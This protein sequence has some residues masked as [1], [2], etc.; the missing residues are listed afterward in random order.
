MDVCVV[1]HEHQL[2]GLRVERTDFPIIPP[3]QDALPIAHEPHAITLQI[4]HLNSQQLLPILRIPHPN[5]I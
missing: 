4:R 1:D 2:P 5:V 3:T